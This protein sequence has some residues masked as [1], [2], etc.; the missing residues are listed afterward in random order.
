M[1]LPERV[2]NI[3]IRGLRKCRSMRFKTAQFEQ[4]QQVIDYRNSENWYRTSFFLQHFRSRPAD[5]DCAL[6]GILD[7]RI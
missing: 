5:P 4:L 7:E 2:K 1:I 3:K 6:I